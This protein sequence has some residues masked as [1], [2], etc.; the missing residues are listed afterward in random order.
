[1]H[2]SIRLY[3]YQREKNETDR[4]LEDQ[5]IT[6]SGQTP[7]RDEISEIAMSWNFVFFS[8]SHHISVS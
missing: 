1:M 4:R 5:R 6:S 8:S 7:S 3:V 2:L